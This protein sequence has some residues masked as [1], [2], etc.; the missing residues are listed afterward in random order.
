MVIE[1]LLLSDVNMNVDFNNKSYEV[2]WWDGETLP[3]PIA[4]DTE[5]EV[6]PSYMVP[7]MALC[8]AYA[9]GDTAYCIRSSDISKFMDKHKECKMIFHNAA[10]DIRVLEEHCSRS[11]LDL[12]KKSM[13]YDTSIMYRLM[14]LAVIGWVPFK[15]NLAML[16]EK[17]LNQK[18][19]KDDSIRLE[20]GPYVG[21]EQDLPSDMVAYAAKDVIATYDIYWHLRSEIEKTAST[22]LL[23]QNIQVAGDYVLKRIH[24]NGIGFDLAKRDEWLEAKNAEL[25]T[26]VSRLASW[27]WVRGTKGIQERYEQALKFLGIDK[28]LPRTKD[29][30]ISS[31]AEDLEAFR[32][33]QF[34]DD[35]L[36]Y[37]ELEKA[38]T[39]V[40]DVCTDVVHPRYNILVN[41]GRTSCS[42][43]NF[44]QLP[45]MGGIREMFIAGPGKKLLITDYSTLELAT[46]AQVLLDKYGSSVM[47]DK[48]N[49]GEDLHRYY[50]SVLY[51]VSEDK[52]TKEQR[53]SA[54]A[55][56][57]GFPGG[58]GVNTFI[59]FSRGYGLELSVK[60]AEEMKYT[61][62][63]AFPEMAQ[64]LNGEIGK[65][66]TRTGRI[67]GDTTFCAEKNTPFQGLAADGAKLA[68][69]YLQEAGFKIVGYVH[70]EIITEVDEADID[71]LLPI[72]EK[73]MIDSMNMV[74]P[75]VKISVESQVSECYKK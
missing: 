27:G 42:K 38:T 2:K 52:V 65:V 67:R 75:D 20:F 47:A 5:T 16:S 29:G 54:K 39:F 1:L 72:Q 17:F 33:I 9:G 34:I 48:I 51:D 4:L 35:Y 23:S 15:Y 12:Y 61:W 57:F 25:K 58:L 63:Q 44:Q 26:L 70:D 32:S 56:N 69:F 55:A 11:F 22:T 73:I 13:I 18:L 8:Q 30:S 41:T 40:R 74:A 31:K 14:H 24:E 66:I 37:I 28:L 60:Q 6:K 71:R 50:A 53:Q 45:R 36:R 43:P 7:K 10:F 62:F 68:L 21:R 59:E 19:S 64:Y 46:L 49:N 3:S